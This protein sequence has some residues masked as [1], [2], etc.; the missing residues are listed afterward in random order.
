[1]ERMFLTVLAAPNRL[2]GDKRDNLSLYGGPQVQ[3]LGVLF[4]AAQ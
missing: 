4:Y 1:M 2:G 3:K